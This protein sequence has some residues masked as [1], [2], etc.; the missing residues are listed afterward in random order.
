MTGQTSYWAE[1]AILL[2]LVVGALF[3]IVAWLIVQTLRKIDQSQTDLFERMRAAEIQLN[4]LQGEHN[5]MKV[6]C[7]RRCDDG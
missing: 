5:A 3:L 6:A 4:T 1:N 2:Q 7:N